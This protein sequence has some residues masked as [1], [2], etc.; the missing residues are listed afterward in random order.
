MG[1]GGWNFGL[2]FGLAGMAFGFTA[3]CFGLWRRHRREIGALDI[4]RTYAAQGKEAPAEVTTLL[5]TVLHRNRR[6][7]YWRMAIL[8]ACLTLAFSDIAWLGVGIR[9]NH[10]FVI[11]TLILGALTAW[12]ILSALL[13]P[14]HD[15]P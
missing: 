1:P 7:K 13:Q 3:M 12:S 2:I 9:P 15:G 14:R 5:Q 4:L 10:A 8:F 6:A 11:P